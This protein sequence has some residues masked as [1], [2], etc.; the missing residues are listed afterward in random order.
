MT[1][2]KTFVSSYQINFQVFSIPIGGMLVRQPF[3]IGGSGSTYLYGHCDYSFKKNMSKEDCVKFVVQGR[4][5]DCVFFFKVKHKRLLDWKANT[6]VPCAK[7]NLLSLIDVPQDQHHT[8]SHNLLWFEL[9]YRIGN[10]YNMLNH[11]YWFYLKF[12][13]NYSF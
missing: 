4:K 7:L 11:F 1:E 13:F 5:K 10:G 6:S 9:F 8:W 12:S 2:S 3:T